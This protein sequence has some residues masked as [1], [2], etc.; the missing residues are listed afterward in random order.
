MGLGAGVVGATEL[1]SNRV[2][3]STGASVLRSTAGEFT[4]RSVYAFSSNA[5]LCRN[6]G[7]EGLLGSM[8]QLGLEFVSDDTRLLLTSR[9]ANSFARVVFA[10]LTNG[11]SGRRRHSRNGRQS[12]QCISVEVEEVS[13]PNLRAVAALSSMLGFAVGSDGE[14]LGG[15]VLTVFLRRVVEVEGDIGTLADEAVE[16]GNL[17]GNG[18]KM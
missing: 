12:R 8:E 11:V 14:L 18:K 5:H 13:N 6:S 4:R 2:V 16:T 1:E 3:V 15:H 10:V 7:V 9:L 17:A